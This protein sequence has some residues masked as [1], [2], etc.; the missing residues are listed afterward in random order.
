MEKKN[1]AMLAG[2]IFVLMVAVIYGVNVSQGGGLLQRQQLRIQLKPNLD[3]DMELW[4]K[5]ANISSRNV[6]AGTNIS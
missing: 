4:R 5:N 1:S 6:P 3:G 2:I